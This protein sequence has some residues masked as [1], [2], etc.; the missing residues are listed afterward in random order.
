VTFLGFRPRDDQAASLGHEVRTWFEVLRALGAYAGDDDPSVVSR[1]TPYLATAFPNGATVVAAHYRSHVESWPGGFHR[2]ARQ[3][4]AALAT[5]PLPSDELRLE[6]LRVHGH[7]VNFRGRLVVGFRL[8]DRQRLVAFAG[9]HG[10]RIG[11]D[12]H[13]HVFADRPV[14]FVAWAPVA[15]HRRVPGGAVAEIWVQGEGRIRVPLSEQ[16]KDGRLFAA[17]RRPGEAGAPMPSRTEGS[18]LEFD[19]GPGK[20]QGKLY[21]LPAA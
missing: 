9:R 2:D 18:V 17:G 4:E 12:D 7:R 19:A 8:D 11:I 10:D 15:A 3:D 14:A 21:L 1:T 5:N 13:D 20:A 16:V 6:A